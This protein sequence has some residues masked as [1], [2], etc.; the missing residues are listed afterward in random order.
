MMLYRLMSE[1]EYKQTVNNNKFVFKGRYKYFTPYICFVT[2]RILGTNFANRLLKPEKYTHL[3]LF[4]IENNSCKFFDYKGKEWVLDKRKAH[5][6][7]IKNLT[8]V[9]EIVVT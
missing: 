7:R 5:N 4:E 6:V 9:K 8:L 1:E 2:Y 3:L